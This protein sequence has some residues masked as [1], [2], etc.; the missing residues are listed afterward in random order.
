VPKEPTDNRSRS[1][2]ELGTTLAIV[3]ALADPNIL[4][5]RVPNLIRGRSVK[6]L[7]L[8]PWRLWVPN[9]SEQVGFHSPNLELRREVFKLKGWSQLAPVRTRE[10]TFPS[11]NLIV[12][13]S[14]YRQS[15]Q[16]N[17]IGSPLGPPSII[18]CHP[19]VG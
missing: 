8:K 1:L 11:M 12:K 19:R 9:R 3:S 10:F 5:T 4:G 7:L 17:G 6:S 2:T 18:Y 16:P 14:A 15:G 13:G